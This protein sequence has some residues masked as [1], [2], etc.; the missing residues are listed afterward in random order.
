MRM[1]VLEASR[2]SWQ[3][4]ERG[5][6][7]DL[8]LL[9]SGAAAFRFV[10]ATVLLHLPFVY[11]KVRKRGERMVGET[12]IFSSLRVLLC[13]PQLPHERHFCPAV[14]YIA[15]HLLLM[16]GCPPFFIFRKVFNL[17]ARLT[18]FIP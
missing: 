12:H 15:L 17:S 9:S 18:D 4:T 14:K 10:P 3:E 7:A 1:W 2:V 11:F 16:R 8:I 13:S 6:C 5:R